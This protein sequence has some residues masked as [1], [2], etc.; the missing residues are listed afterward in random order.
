MTSHVLWER[1]S[2]IAFEDVLNFCAA[3]E[4][5]PVEITNEYREDSRKALSFV[6]RLVEDFAS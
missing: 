6:F 3:D 4:I 5:E 1:T 2:G